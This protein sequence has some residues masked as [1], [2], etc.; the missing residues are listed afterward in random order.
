VAC[1]DKS[2]CGAREEDGRGEGGNHTYRRPIS[3][4][5]SFGRHSVLLTDNSVTYILV[6][7]SGNNFGSNYGAEAK[8]KGYGVYIY[9]YKFVTQNFKFYYII[10][11]YII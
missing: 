2:L 11:D 5:G 4:A 7:T 8:G 3:V 6:M 1:N 10:L 9:I